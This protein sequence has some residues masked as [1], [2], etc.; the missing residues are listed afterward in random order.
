M[1]L[2]V[3]ELWLCPASVLL[4]GAWIVTH[5]QW[6]YLNV[7][8]VNSCFGPSNYSLAHMGIELQWRQW[9]PRAASTLSDS[10]WRA[11]LRIV[12][13]VESAY[14]EMKCFIPTTAA[15]EHQREFGTHTEDPRHTSRFEYL[16]NLSATAS[17]FVILIIRLEDN[18]RGMLVPTMTGFYPLH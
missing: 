10:F 5:L 4:N 2:T 11:R 12:S 15:S 18:T 16:Q 3:L 9:F 1:Q 8:S 13:A 14:L 7:L 6:E 17:S